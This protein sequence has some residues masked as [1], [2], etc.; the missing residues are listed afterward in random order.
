MFPY[1]P[2]SEEIWGNKMDVCENEYWR[3]AIH[4]ESH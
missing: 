2:V 1:T 4:V 3:K